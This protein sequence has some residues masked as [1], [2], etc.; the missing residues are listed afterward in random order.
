MKGYSRELKENKDHVA[1]KNFK[2]EI[3]STHTLSQALKQQTVTRTKLLNE[4]EN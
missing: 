4:N 3:S 2:N 1:C